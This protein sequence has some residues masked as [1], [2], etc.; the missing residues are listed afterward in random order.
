MVTGGEPSKVS[1]ALGLTLVMRGGKEA[2]IF[3]K[4]DM[5]PILV[6]FIYALSFLSG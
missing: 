6:V 3:G 1:N 2:I 5:P 4:V